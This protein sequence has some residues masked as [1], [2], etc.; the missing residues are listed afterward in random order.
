MPEMTRQ[1]RIAL[2][3]KQE[4]ISVKSGNDK[5]FRHGEIAVRFTDKGL[6]QYIKYKGQD[7][8]NYLK[9]DTDLPSIEKLTDSTGGTASNTIANT[10][11]SA[12]TTA[13]FENAIASL[14]EK[15]NDILNVL[16]A[17]RLIK[18]R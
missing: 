5:N 9:L 4:K 15:V 10:A 18:K 2:R 12:P 8:V 13:E 6:A 17:N 7:Y 11:G 16:K 3:K 14:T 1:E